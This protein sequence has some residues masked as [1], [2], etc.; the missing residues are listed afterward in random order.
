MAYPN[1]NLARLLTTVFEPVQGSRVCILIDLD[2]PQLIKD[3]AF[4]DRDGYSVQKK[5]HEV[6]YNG[7]QKGVAEE[8]NLSGGDIFAFQTTGGSNLDLPDTCVSPDGE[9]HQLEEAVYPKYDLILCIS[10]Y[11]ATAP[12]TAFAKKYGFRGSTMHGLNDIILAS[13]L[14]VN[15]EE[16]SAEAEKLRLGM[17]HADAV[18]I[19]TEIDGRKE[20]L[21]IELGKQDAQ[22]SHGLC[23]GTAPDIAN[24]PAGEVYYVPKSAEG[25]FPI[26]HEDGTITFNHVKDGSIVDIEL[27]SGDPA[28]VAAHKAKITS[29]PVTGRLGELGFG[30]QVLP[31]AEADIQDE[32]VLGTVHVA[33]GRSDHLGGDL[34][35]SMFAEAS[36]ATHDDLLLHPLKTPEINLTQVRLYRN[37]REE[38]LIENYKPAAYMM[39]LLA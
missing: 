6:F 31:F 16:V 25:C 32:K 37:G 34:L 22:K 35:P 26:K 29:D 7:L 33:T 20:T 15:Y 27:V 10:D 12:L 24:L 19:D 18:E 36:N 9:T 28:I 5:A 4:L 17:T 38:V 3:F 8:L 1:F 13:G 39:A 30:T 14:S 23:K 11:S 2:D 21:R